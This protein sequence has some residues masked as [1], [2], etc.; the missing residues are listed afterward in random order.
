[1]KQIPYGR[2]DIDDLDI[3]EVVQVLRSD[4][5]TQG[6]AIERFEQAISHYCDA[7]HALAVCNATAGLHLAC[8]AIGLGPGDTLWTSPNTFVASANCAFYCG[9]KVDFVDI[10]P[11]TYNMSVDVLEAKLEQARRARSLPKV[12]VPVHFAGQPCNMRKIGELAQRYGF[13]VIEDAAHAIGAKYQD[14]KVGSCRYS[15]ITVFSF[16]PVKIITT[17][18]GG[19][20]TTQRR[21]LYEKIKLLRSHGITREPAQMTGDS[22]GG[23]YYEQIDLGYNY[24][25]TDIQAALGVSQLRKLDVF[26]RRRHAIAHRYDKEL[27]DLPVVLPWQHPDSHSAYHLYPIKVDINRTEVSRGVLFDGLRKR[28]VMVNVH[29]IPVHT[30]PYF[31]KHGFDKKVFPVAEKY[32][33]QAIS[34]PMYSRLS[35]DDQSFVIQALREILH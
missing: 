22:H 6:P 31:R 1:M 13:S 16:H 30:Q 18:E 33:E 15:D 3:E 8:R 17:G 28:G 10:D 25:M 26:V 34:L 35:D 20:L 12:V 21:D 4:W 11:R 27:M 23:W 9:A 29:Y 5:I 32:Y 7:A 2:Q 14:D 19:M 24:R